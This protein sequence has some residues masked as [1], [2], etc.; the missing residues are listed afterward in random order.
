MKT[1]NC[2]SR[3]SIIPPHILNELRKHPNPVVSK[4]AEATIFLTYAA[5][6]K[7][8]ILAQGMRPPRPT[9]TLRRTIY[10]GGQ[11]AQTHGTILRSEGQ[12]PVKDAA[13]NEAYDA[14]GDTYNFY[15]AIFGRNSVDGKGLRLDSTV[16]YREDPSQAFDNA[17]W[18]GEEML[19][20]DGD[21]VIFGRFTKS[22]DVIGH[23]LT[24]G[25]TQYTA[26]LEYHDQPGALNE[27]MSD[28]FGTMVKQWQNKQTVA[29]ADWLIGAELF[30][31]PSLALRS[32]K[33]PGT[34]YKNVPNIGSDP[35]PANMKDYMK[36]PNTRA[37]DNGGVHV[38][39]G[40]PNRAFYL[41]CVNLKATYSWEKPG[42][43]WYAT[44]TTRLTSSATFAEAAQATISVANEL[45]GPDDAKAVQAAWE[46]VGVVPGGQLT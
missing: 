13:A 33:A 6:V 38:N 43:I 26:A 7:R 21:G 4:A 35:Q 42:K 41:A 19:Y 10:D 16:H 20:G 29:A 15:K 40:I 12:S 18:D 9:G 44:L 27:S 28:V 32:M 23:E 25:V 17:E 31:Q 22:L 34:A 37:G 30:L 45:G 5:R 1:M 2:P 14:S 46:E 3:C 11:I 8:G 36:L 39:S 24:H